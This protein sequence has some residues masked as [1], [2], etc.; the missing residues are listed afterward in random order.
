[1]ESTS[2][3][4]GD[5]ANTSEGLANQQRIMAAQF[6]QLQIT[7]GTALLPAFTAVA[8]VVNTV[9]IPAFAGAFGWIMDNLPT[10]ITFVS[11]LGT[12]LIAFNA[13]AIA[14]KVWAIA[15]GILNAVMAINPLTLLAIAIAAVVAAIVW[16]ATETTFFQDAWQVM[17]EAV[18]VA[19]EAVVGF[20][21]TAFQAIGDFFGG[22][23]GVS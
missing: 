13:V 9:L 17:T 14:T 20:F 12:L 15:Q 3:T 21:E 5:F 11:V 19:W 10:V 18:T 1:M 6:G 7:I 4:Q 2:K 8:S 23:I 16:I 22:L